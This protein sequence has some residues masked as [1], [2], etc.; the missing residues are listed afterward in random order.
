MGSVLASYKKHV[1]SARYFPVA[2][3]TEE[4]GLYKALPL[5]PV[6]L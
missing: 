2:I 4:L 1:F 5:H 6:W 3:Q